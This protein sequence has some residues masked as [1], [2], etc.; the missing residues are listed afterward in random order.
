LSYSASS[1][2]RISGTSTY[3]KKNGSNFKLYTS[4]SCSSNTSFAE[5]SQGEAYWASSSTL[6]VHDDSSLNAITF[7]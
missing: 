4:S 2:T 1:C 5:V 7:N 3:V 6:V